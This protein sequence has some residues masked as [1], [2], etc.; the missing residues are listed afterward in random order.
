ML[1][2]FPGVRSVIFVSTVR[3]KQV[4]MKMVSLRK[5]GDVY[6]EIYMYIYVIRDIS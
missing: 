6:K 4:G 1:L 5:I 2:M 3:T